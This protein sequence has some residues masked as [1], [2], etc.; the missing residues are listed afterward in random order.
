MNNKKKQTV[1]V[2]MA[3]V[4]SVSTVVNP[5]TVRAQENEPPVTQGIAQDNVNGKKETG[6]ETAPAIA[7]PENLQATEGTPLKEIA[8][9]E[10]WTWADESTILS[11]DV[12]EYPAYVTVDDET[13]DY[14]AVEGYHAEGHYVEVRLSVAVELPE[15]G[16]LS[17]SAAHAP[18]AADDVEI[19]EKN[20]PD[21]AFRNYIAQ[22]IDKNKNGF[23]SETEIADVNY[24]NLSYMSDVESLKGLEY[25]TSMTVLNCGG[26][27]IKELDIEPNEKLMGLYVF[28]NMNITTLNTSANANLEGIY[29]YNTAIDSLNISKNKKLTALNCSGTKLETLDVS[30]N[31]KLAGL[32]CHGTEIESID[33]SKNVD[34]TYLRCNNTK[35]KSI[36][37]SNCTKLQELTCNGTPLAY[38]NIGTNALLDLGELNKPEPSSTELKEKTKTFN[39]TEKFPG[40]DPEKITVTNGAKYDSTTGIVSE[41][42]DQAPIEYSY[43]CGT[44]KD[45]PVT[46]DVKLKVIQKEESSIKITDNDLD[47][48]YNGTAV[49]NEPAVTKTGSTGAV[50]YTWEKQNR[51]MSWEKIS[52]APTDAGNYRVTAHVAADDDYKAADS[53]PKEFTIWRADNNWISGLAIGDWTYGTPANKPSATPRFGTVSYTYSNSQTGTFK[54]NVPTAAGTWYVKGAVAGT[55][56]YTELEKTIDFKITKANAPAITLPNNLSGIQGELL[57]TVKLPSGWVWEDDSQTLEIGNNGYKARFAV[58]DSNYDYTGVTDYDASGHY[59]EKVLSV[60]VSL[61]QNNWTV[62]PSIA[63]W[64]YGETASTPA[65]RAA[66]GTTTFTYSDSKT[67]TFKE[68]IPTTAGTWYVKAAVA[69][70]DNYTGLEKIIEFK[71][72][73]ANAPAI[74]LPNNLSG[75]QGDLLSTV[76]LPSGWVWGDDSQTLEIGNNGYNARFAVDDS[77][78]DYTGVTDY[79]ASGHYVEKVLSVTLSLKQNNWTVTPSIADWTYGETASTPAGRAAYGTATFTYSDSETG[80]FSKEVP[81]AAGIWYMKASVAAANEY[82]GLDTIVKFMIMPK[83]MKTDNQIK[84][85]EISADTNLNELTLMD[86]GKVL[87][88]GKDYDVA[89]KQNGNKVTVTITFKGNY[90]GTIVKTYTVNDKNKPSGKKDDPNRSVQT[91]DTTS[92]GLWAMLMT[93]AAGTAALLKGKKRKEE[94]EE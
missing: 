16:L 85:P 65:G 15:E 44:Y 42:S 8:L 63:D 87:V 78:Y 68:D 41:Y 86:G 17:R 43:D 12:T 2:A 72:T 53:S 27:S 36:D 48:S 21:E 26:T 57:S 4:L 76:K 90:T 67:G 55:D 19:N 60:T 77:N 23:L 84:I 13:Y 93:A 18:Y 83:D 11:A 32:D 81:T 39:I 69:G 47:K 54:E 52:G 50:N 80:A 6:K 70:T 29:C 34:L 59:V 56:N 30:A 91:G 3:A 22:G 71:I 38:L 64:T 10:N 40:I 46:L 9:P 14:A 73:K 7:L 24:I 31:T 66:Y 75:I 58:D 5:I 74:T 89:K 92:A 51:A 25:F 37:V 35:V 1:A 82:T 62:A 49:S 28:N 88:Q 20:F 79:D 33:V 61:E 94:T 45:N